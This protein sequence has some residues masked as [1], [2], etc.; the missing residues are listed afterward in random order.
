ML[1]PKLDL[2]VTDMQLL[3]SIQSFKAWF[4]SYAL[5]GCKED[6]IQRLANT[7]KMCSALY[8]YFFFNF[9]DNDRPPLPSIFPGKDLFPWF[10]GHLSFMRNPRIGFL[11]SDDLKC[12]AQAR[13]SG[14]SLPPPNRK[15]QVKDILDTFYTLTTEKDVPE[16]VLSRISEASE[17][18]AKKLNA[19]EAEETSHF[20][21]SA[22]AEYSYTR[23]SGGNLSACRE[24]MNPYLSFEFKDCLVKSTGKCLDEH[25]FL[26]EDEDETVGFDVYDPFGHIMHKRAHKFQNL[27]GLRTYQ[28]LYM[29][30]AARSGATMVA[31]ALDEPCLGPAFGD[32]MALA[33]ISEA[34]RLKHFKLSVKPDDW[35][36]IS[37]GV[38]I[39]LYFTKARVTLL[40]T[41]NPVPVRLS[42]QGESGN[43]SR[44]PSVCPMWL[45]ILQRIAKFPIENILKRDGRARIGLEDN[46]KLWSF[47]KVLGRR[48]D[49]FTIIQSSD[50]SNATDEI[51]LSVLGT[52]WSPWMSEI[53]ID[54]PIR[55]I[56]STLFGYRSVELTDKREGI[57]LCSPLRR[58]SLMGESFSFV[59]LTL[60][61]LVV[62]TLTESFHERGLNAQEGMQVP[63]REG[64]GRIDPCAI[65][66]DDVC[67]VRTS[68]DK[69]KLFRANAV[70]C[71]FVISRGKDGNS[72]TSGIFCEDHFFLTENS[73]V[74]YFDT[75]KARLFSTSG[76]TTADFRAVVV[77]RAN[78]LSN[79]VSYLPDEVWKQRIIR[80]F[81]KI[82]LCKYDFIID[83]TIPWFLPPSCGGLGLPVSQVP[84]W[85]FKYINYIIAL[86]KLNPMSR[87]MGFYRLRSLGGRIKHGLNVPQVAFDLLNTAVGH[88]RTSDGEFENRL[89]VCYTSDSINMFLKEQG[90]T[91]RDWE[92]T[93]NLAREYGLISIDE[94]LN[95]LENAVALNHCLLN[96]EDVKPNYKFKRWIQRSSRYWKKV[97]LANEV[98]SPEFKDLSS[99]HKLATQ[100]LG[101]YLR[102]DSGLLLSKYG[103]RLVFGVP[104]T[105]KTP[106]KSMAGASRTGPIP[107]ELRI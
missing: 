7:L 99:L 11:S 31:Q 13:L 103:T 21:V 52:M 67:A 56:E 41:G 81:T 93:V 70:L 51:A 40:P 76:G 107:L 94:F 24:L 55:V 86:S 105:S 46:N 39:P 22:S 78:T 23:E 60:L 65:C 45:S 53:G 96:D 33:A 80:L 71:S 44:I 82:V 61:N 5:T 101:Y 49:S 17:Y 68:L 20:S 92:D 37:A 9:E 3:R 72:P 10:G 6:A 77:G 26:I 1:C 47:L 87:V 100:S 32:L 15:K 42:V 64:E 90:H 14:R 73:K 16:N 43:K 106:M 104:V 30:D 102:A 38:E 27:K 4:V 12:F 84:V 59:S 2:S 62:E 98:L 63:F 50:Y 95:E 35:L 54:H 36:V 91:I 29:T 79:Q 48:K 69:C 28:V 74:E 57:S 34:I 19:C 58:G 88:L 75:I 66:G 83:T 89:N 8:Q 85:G 97:N 18:L 25:L